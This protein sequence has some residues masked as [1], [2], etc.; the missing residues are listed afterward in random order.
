MIA[1]SILKAVR[2]WR[3]RSRANYEL[4]TMSDRQLADIGISRGD[5]DAVVHGRLVRPSRHETRV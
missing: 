2:E 5:I 3:N 4:S 1:V